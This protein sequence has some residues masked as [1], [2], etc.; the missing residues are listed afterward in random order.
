MQH[1]LPPRPNID[2]LLGWHQ[3]WQ[4]FENGFYLTEESG[5]ILA[6]REKRQHHGVQDG[7]GRIV[8]IQ[9]FLK[10]FRFHAQPPAV[11]DPER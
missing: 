1:H 9:Y 5:F 10:F 6:L 3:F 2:S 4:G 11:L 8:A 7:D